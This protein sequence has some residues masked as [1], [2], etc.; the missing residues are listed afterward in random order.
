[1]YNVENFEFKFS[2]AKSHLN[3]QIEVLEITE[4]C[5][6]ISQKQ[7]YLICC[8]GNLQEQIDQEVII[9][10]SATSDTNLGRFTPSNFWRQL[11][12]KFKYVN[13]TNSH[14]YELKQ[15]Q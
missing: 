3:F 9:R 13:V 8:F 5:S 2:R 1:M 15:N 12:L 7:D 11:F 6:M 10:V 14:F 4:H